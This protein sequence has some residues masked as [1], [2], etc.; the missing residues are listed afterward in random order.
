MCSDIC[1]LNCINIC[2][3]E[4]THKKYINCLILTDFGYSME[5]FPVQ[6][7]PKRIVRLTRVVPFHSF[8]PEQYILSKIFGTAKMLAAY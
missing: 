4:Y 6:Q 7:S 8:R 1:D 5:N 2:V 3:H